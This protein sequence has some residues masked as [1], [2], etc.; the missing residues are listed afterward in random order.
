MNSNRSL[1][2]TLLRAVSGFIRL[3]WAVVVLLAICLLWVVLFILF[4]PFLMVSALLAWRTRLTTPNGKDA[5]VAALNGHL[6]ELSSAEASGNDQF[7]FDR[8]NDVSKVYG[9]NTRSVKYRWTIFASRLDEIRARLK[10]PHAL[11]FGAG[12]LRD[13]YE[14]ARLGFR[15]VS[16]DLDSGLLKSYSKAYDWSR[17]GRQPQFYTGPFEELGSQPDLRKFDLAL[18]FDVIEHLEDPAGYLRQ[19]HP[20]LADSGFLFAIVPNRL[21]LFERYFK[22]SLRK[23]RRLGVALQRG[24][25]HLQFKS[26]AEWAAFFEAQGFRVVEHDMTLGFLVNDVW[27]GLLTIP[28]RSQVTPALSRAAGLLG[29]RFDAGAFEQLF[30]PA[31]LMERVHV[32]DML[33]ARSLKNRFGWNLLVVQKD[34]GR[35]ESAQPA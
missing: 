35:P 30:V 28:I 20:L 19:L 21:S 31:W 13:S 26:P 32:L 8:R 9:C 33:L 4:L 2:Q 23:Q 6:P 11:D 17:A 7:I 15:V 34:P 12:S 25:P 27:N 1:S 22:R 18:S 29:V 5:E 3:V 10:E 16:V 24:V 14:L